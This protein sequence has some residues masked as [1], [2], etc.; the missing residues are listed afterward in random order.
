MFGRNVHYT[1][2]NE[3]PDWLDDQSLAET[4]E[5]LGGEAGLAGT[6]M[7]ER[8]AES[9]LLKGYQDCRGWRRQTGKEWYGMEPGWT[10]DTTE[11]ELGGT[12]ETKPNR[13]EENT[14][15]Q[16]DLEGKEG[17]FG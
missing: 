13:S 14:S 5:Q 7:G 16:E 10:L 15:R 12:R 2:S 3:F 11:E 6:G 8:G 1:E 4:G 9:K 17:G